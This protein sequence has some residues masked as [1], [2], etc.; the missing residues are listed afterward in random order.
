[1]AASLLTLFLNMGAQLGFWTILIAHIMFCLSFVVTAVKARVMSMDPRLEEAAQDLYAGP[2]QTFLRVTLP[3]AVARHRGGRAAR[4]RAL[5]R[6]LH[7]HQ[8]QRGL[9]RDLP[10]VRL[11]LG[12]ARHARA[13]QR[14]R[15]G[16][17]HHR[18]RWW[19]PPDSSL[20]TGA[21]TARK[22][23][24]TQFLR[25]LE[26][27]AVTRAMNSAGTTVPGGRQARP[28]LAGGPRP[29]RGPARP[30]RRREVRPARRRRRLQ[31]AVDRAHRQGARPRP[32][33]RPHRGQ[34]DRLGRLRPQRR[35][36]RRLPH[37]RPRQ[38]PGPLAGRAGQARRAGRGATS[39]PSRRAVARYGID[40]DF[41]RTGEI[42]VATEPHQLE[43]LREMYEEATELGFGGA[44]VPR[45]GRGCA[46]R[47]TRP[48][49]SAGSGTAT[50]WPCST[51]PSSPGASSAPASI[52]AY[53]S[54]STPR[55]SRWPGSAPAWACAPRTARSAP[56]TW[57]SAPTCSPPW[58]SGCGR[59]P[60]RCTTTR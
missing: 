7:H 25:E 33:R 37:P 55:A 11:G 24:R 23:N 34:G 27:M 41:E 49:S 38:R 59:T 30:H 54:T 39:T 18:R 9:H 1:M 32:R 22:R 15:D 45:R 60:S 4:L 58:S 46:P 10:H 16:H 43:E 36:L 5:L 28:V 47:S 2:V 42:D 3:I 26:I 29:P 50:A 19:S 44:R 53:G 6:R 57:R 17:V 48:P 31:R 56:S 21:R 12:A 13:D 51:R 14:H 35:L 20:R 8:L 40:C 52:S